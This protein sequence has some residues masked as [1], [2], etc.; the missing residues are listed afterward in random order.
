[1]VVRRCE[2]TDLKCVLTEMAIAMP[3]IVR[4]CEG[5]DR[6]CV[7]PEKAIAPL[8]IVRQCPVLGKDLDSRIS[9]VQKDR[10]MAI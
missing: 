8:W 7:L 5:T 1:M 6:K 10:I 4:L 2:E 3:W 9:D